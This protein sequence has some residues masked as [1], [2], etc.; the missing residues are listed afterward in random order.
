MYEKPTLQR[1][2]TFRELTLLG[3]SSSTDGASIFGIGSPGCSTTIGRHTYEIGCPS[4]GP[5]TS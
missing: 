2:G 5:T 4:S 3:F 1:F